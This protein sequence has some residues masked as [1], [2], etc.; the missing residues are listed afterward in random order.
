MKRFHVHV[1]VDN[2]GDASGLYAALF[3]AQPSVVKPDNTKW[4]LDDACCGPQ[5]EPKLQAAGA[6]CTS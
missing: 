6:C 5:A 4:M 1:A 2:L 3:A